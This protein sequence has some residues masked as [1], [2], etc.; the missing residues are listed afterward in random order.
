MSHPIIHIYVCHHRPS[1]L[2]QDDVFKPIHV[3]AALSARALDMETDMGSESISHKN[4][5][6]CELTAMYWAWKNDS[7]ADWIGLMHYRRFLAFQDTKSA[8]D[9]YGCI[10]FDVLNEDTATSTGLNSMTVRKHIEN[11][12]ALKAILPTKWDVRNIGFDSIADHYRESDYHHAKDLL[13]TRQVISER[14]PSY[15]GHFDHVLRGSTGY[16]TNVFVLQRQIFNAYCEWLFDILFEVEKRTDLTNYSVA[17]RRI[18]GY[19]AE[20]LLNVYLTSLN[21]QKDEYLELRRTFFQNTEVPA[22]MPTLPPPPEN[23]MSLVIASDNNFVPH[24]AALIESIKDTTPEQSYL[25]ICVLDGGISPKNRK[26]LH[27]QFLKDLKQPGSLHFLDCS[28][29]YKDVDVHMHFSTS[30][31]YRIDLGSILPNH[32][33][34]IYIDCDTIVQGDLTELWNLDLN[35]KAVAAV[36]DLIMKNF[37]RHRTPAMKAAGGM[38]AADYLSTYVGLG[39]AIDDY[40]QAGVIV[41]DL[42]HYRQLN[43]ANRA[44]DDLKSKRY[45]FLDQDILNKYLVGQVK[46]LDTSWN[47]VNMIMDILPG[48]NAEWAAKAKQ[49]F[50]AP[51]IIHYA[52]FEAKPWNNHKAPWAE[53]YWYYLRKTYW[54]ESVALKFPPTSDEGKLINKGKAYVMLRSLWRSLPNSV[55]V[56]LGAAMHRFN[57]WYFK[58]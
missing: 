25:Q 33:K 20:R 26:L 28:H 24:L 19:L 10:N 51:K 27:M 43:V 11:N 36:P 44:L 4:R 37:V 18:Y 14:C 57:R 52:G 17:G 45:W 55:K 21:L 22:P 29:L 34:V 7:S 58:L 54:Y 32:A 9:M 48:L 42:A 23:G 53:V 12:S 50:A 31:F 13:T 56:N 35:S 5:E 6:Y 49:D 40:F 8:A 15:L 3:G 16:F 46:F 1:Y 47:C 38:P 39:S 41:F 2:V 30:T